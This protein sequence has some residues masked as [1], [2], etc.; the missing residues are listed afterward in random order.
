M[1]ATINGSNKADSLIGTA[2]ADT[3]NG[4]RGNDWLDG[5]GGDDILTGG[6]GRDVFILRAGGGDDVVTDFSRAEG[7]RVLFDYGTYSDVFAP[8]GRLED[9]QTFNNFNDSATWT[10]DYDDFNGDGNTDV[11]LTV[12]YAGGQDSITLLGVGDLYSGDLFGG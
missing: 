7:D 6:E 9:G 5:R 4:R 12:D 2:D 1:M 3:L 8:L 10:V 11:R